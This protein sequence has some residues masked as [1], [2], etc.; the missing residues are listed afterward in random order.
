MQDQELQIRRITDCFA[1]FHHFS[2][3]CHLSWQ[4]GYKTANDIYIAAWCDWYNLVGN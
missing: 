1:L 2:K 4:P 3:A